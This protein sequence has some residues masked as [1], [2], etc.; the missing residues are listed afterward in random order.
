MKILV[1]A[2]YTCGV[3]Y[4]WCL[5]VALV[6][7]LAIVGNQVD[8]TYRKVEQAEAL[9][10][11]HSIGALCFE[12]SAKTNKG[13]ETTLRSDKDFGL[14]AVVIADVYFIRD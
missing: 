4:K 6:I 12:T 9:E 11:A 14:F 8:R 7:V 13:K 3:C 10:Y 2:S 5:S 1:S